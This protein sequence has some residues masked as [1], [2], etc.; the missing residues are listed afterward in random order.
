M[1]DVKQKIWEVL[2]QPQLASLATLT[3]DGR[4]WSRY[5]MA[6]GDKDLVL[7]I[8]TSLESR[9]VAQIRKSP[10][11]HLHMGVASLESAECYLQ[12]AGR[13]EV[14][15]DERTR[16]AMWTDNLEAY[17]SGWDDPKFCVIEVTP[18]RI[19]HWTMASME[20]DVWEP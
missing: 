20:P 15:T 3:E 2:G 12:I 19:E 9:K 10:E 14:K 1:S 13:A 16:K 7:R 4:P 11:V 5:V 18:R 17:F 8:S 6:I